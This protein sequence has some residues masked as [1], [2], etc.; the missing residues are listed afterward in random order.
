MLINAKRMN[1]EYG[2][3]DEVM[4]GF[5]FFF[6]TQ[7]IIV[8]TSLPATVLLTYLVPQ[9]IEASTMALI[10]GT[11]V[12]THEVG[13]KISASIYCTVFDVDN[14]HLENYPRVLEAKILALAVM[15]VL[16]II[17]PRNEQI[18]KLAAKLRAEHQ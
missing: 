1:L 5:I 10:S 3:S 16:T 8:L 6:S 17:I 2:V 4:N 13:A 18:L 9:N 15:I 11:F 7:L 12:V 14:D